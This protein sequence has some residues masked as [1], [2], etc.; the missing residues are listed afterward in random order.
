MRIDTHT[1]WMP[2][3]YFS[4]MTEFAST[5]AAFARGNALM[6]GMDAASKLRRLDQRL[7][8]MDGAGIDIAVLSLPPPSVF[9]GSRA[10]AMEAAA[11]ANNELVAGAKSARRRFRVLAAVPLPHVEE[12]IAELDRIG[13]HP[14]VRGVGLMTQAKGWTL[15]D[16]AFEPFYARAAE[17]DLPVVLHPQ[18]EDLP[19]A[20]QRW[21]LPASFAPMVSSSLGA[22]R[23]ILSGMLD[24]AP[25]LVP[26]V[27]HLGGTIPYL[28]QRLLD[29]SGTG[30]AEHDV[31]YYCRHRLYYDTCSFHT[32]ALRC[33]CDTAGSDRL[34]LGSDYPFRGGL[35][36]CVE[37]IKRSGLSEE[38]Q[39]AIFSATAA[40]WFGPDRDRT[41]GATLPM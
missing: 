7:Q 26:I 28:A 19:A 38:E 6:L 10:F 36:R 34:M 41:S 15:D 14:L 16:P 30:D 20:Y 5:D 27:P 35:E 22:L 29:Q 23:L 12:A 18:L 21:G 1:H 3:S 39:A 31:L 2:P 4:A 40:R 17:L 25:N 32:P 11:S 33:A 24:R 9:F 13:R 37:D 8:E